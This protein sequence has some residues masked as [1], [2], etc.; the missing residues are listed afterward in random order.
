MHKTSHEPSL[1]RVTLA[2]ARSRFAQESHLSLRLQV[3]PPS[4][5]S[6]NS[7]LSET[8][9]RP[10]NKSRLWR[11]ST[12]TLKT[13][14]GSRLGESHSPKQDGLSPKTKSPRLSEM[15]KQKKVYESLCNTPGSSWAY[16]ASHLPPSNW[17][18]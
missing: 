14:T 3:K 8:H 5:C 9:F 16:Q 10:N 18:C 17:L 4:E 13:H 6:S 11:Y 15:L 12:N 1:R 2:W 7:R